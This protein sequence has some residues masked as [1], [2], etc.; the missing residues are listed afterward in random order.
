MNITVH[1]AFAVLNPDYFPIT[2]NVGDLEKN[3][4]RHAVT[5]GIEAG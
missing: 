2:V 1:A 3:D 5:G 4:L